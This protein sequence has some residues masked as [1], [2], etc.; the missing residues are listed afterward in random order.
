V[1]ESIVLTAAGAVLGL[2]LAY[3]AIELLLALAPAT[4]PRVATVGIDARVLVVTFATSVVVA[5]VFG[6]VPTLQAWRR[7]LQ[8]SIRDNSGRSA[9]AGR[10][11]RRVR[12]ALVV[13]ELTLAVMLMTGA[14]LLIQSLWRLQ[15]VD[16]GFAAPGVL[17]AEY[18]LPGSRYPQSFA[19]F[20][21]W[22]EVHRFGEETRRRIA[23]LPGVTSVAL[24][25]NHPLD[26]GNTSSINVVGR[27]SEGVDW[28]EPV[29]R[30]VDQTYFET[31]RVP[32]V[33]GRGFL[34]ADDRATAPVIIIN[35]AARRRFFA[36]QEPLGQRIFLWGAQRLVVGV[37]G[38]ERMYGLSQATPPAVYLPLSQAPGGGG[39][40]LVRTE[41][42]PAQLAS[43]VR[44]AVREIDPALPLFGVE[45]LTHTV[46]ETLGQRRF[47]MLVLVVFAALA[48]LL[49]AIGVH[50][51]LSYTV[52][53]R[54]H[55]I[56]IRM[57]L[58]ADRPAV[59]NLVMTDAA[60]LAGGGVALGLAGGLL[61]T[62]VLTTLLYGVEATD[63]LTFAA[64]ALALG[65]VA[66]L[67]SWLPARRAAGVDPMV[68]LRAD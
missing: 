68:A 46:A 67:A 5:F 21:N 27:E 12:S 8:S 43:A 17:K 37:V 55:E 59:R 23:A 25:A 16:P 57:A 10:R 32:L 42:D 19:N 1:A 53:Q 7:D 49:A 64:V 40:I 31:M 60:R 54:T 61:T 4:I 47:T 14:G 48:L 22:T 11:H 65:G 33:A 30:R 29:I 50:G 51:V 3:A 56:G 38:D 66:L 45:S 15:R 13:V 35:E 18:Q 26:A 63:P 58:G 44:A 52:A 62:R 2:G 41:R 34:A 9:T 28:P 36:T 39:S 24:A 20:P 6:M